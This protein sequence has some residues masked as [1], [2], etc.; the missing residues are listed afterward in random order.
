[1]GKSSNH[2][3]FRGSETSVESG[4][5]GNVKGS[6]SNMESRPTPTLP[7]VIAPVVAFTP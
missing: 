2:T 5:K 7:N 3:V 6:H 4:L 1:M